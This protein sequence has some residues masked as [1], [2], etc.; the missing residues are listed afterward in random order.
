MLASTIILAGVLLV[1][2]APH[3]DSLHADETVPAPGE[4]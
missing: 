4:A 1:I 2:T 3:K